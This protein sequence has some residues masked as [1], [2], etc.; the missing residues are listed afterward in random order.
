[1]VALAAVDAA[2]AVVILHHEGEI[3]S[4]LAA[5]E[6]ERF[7]RE[8]RERHVA[9]VLAARALPATLLR[10]FEITR[11]NVAPPEKVAASIFGGFV[12]YL[13]ILLAYTGAMYPAIDL[14]AGEKERGTMETLLCSPASRVEIVLGKF[15]MVLTGSL[16]A[17]VLALI[18]MG[19]TATL[20]GLLLV[21]GAAKGGASSL[22]AATSASG[23]A[24]TIP[25]VDPLG[26]IGVMAMAL[27][28]AVLFSALIFTIA[29]FARSRTGIAHCPCS[30]MRLGSGILPLRRLL[31]AQ[32]PVG[33]GVDGS[34]SNDGARSVAD[35][36]RDPQ[37][38]RR[39]FSDGGAGEHDGR[40]VDDALER[41]RLAPTP[42]RAG[43]PAALGPAVVAPVRPAHD[44]AQRA[45]VGRAVAPAHDATQRPAVAAAL[46]GAQRAAVADAF[47]QNSP[48]EAQL[49]A[50]LAQCAPEFVVVVR[51][52]VTE[53]KGHARCPVLGRP[54]R[55]NERRLC[56][57]IG[58]GDIVAEWGA[59]HVENEKAAA[60][61]PAAAF[62]LPPRPFGAPTWRASSCEGLS[63]RPRS[64]QA[65]PSAGPARR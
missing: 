43:L 39:D 55:L 65:S 29:L 14:T 7:F 38:L 19:V 31:D 27:P 34:A 2:P 47:R 6:L 11:E 56:K 18:S 59:H 40:G 21:G 5:S 13:I 50:V 36:A 32:V 33:L 12:P 24:G 42:D 63:P 46:G 64:L 16:G 4:G 53:T 26:V 20:S 61:C 1:M 51:A 49:I 8:Y 35:F 3:K 17:M 30:N 58:H 57:L 60:G 23:P 62:Y 44:P 15:L 41:G 45:A 25:M 48:R 52:L 22:A 54:S 37:A 10:P 28:V 9:G